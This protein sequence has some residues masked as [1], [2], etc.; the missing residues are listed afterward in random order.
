MKISKQHFLDVSSTDWC[1]LSIILFY[2][3]LLFFVCWIFQV[4]VF[5]SAVKLPWDLPKINE[6]NLKVGKIF[7]SGSLVSLLKPL[8][9]HDILAPNYYGMK[10]AKPV[11]SVQKTIISEAINKIKYS[12][13]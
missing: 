5:M 4:R 8:I 13:T 3:F 10:Y 6:L 1:N 2:S 12:I 11:S 7:Y 9:A